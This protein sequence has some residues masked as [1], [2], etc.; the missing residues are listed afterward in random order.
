MVPQGFILDAF[1]R[2]PVML[3]MAEVGPAC[4]PQPSGHPEQLQLCRSYGRVPCFWCRLHFAFL[5]RNSAS[6]SLAHS[7]CLVR[8]AEPRLFCCPA[9]ETQVFHGTDTQII[10]LQAHVL[11]AHSWLLQVLDCSLCNSL[12]NS[13]LQLQISLCRAGGLCAETSCESPMSSVCLLFVCFTNSWF[14]SLTTGVSSLPKNPLVCLNGP[15]CCLQVTTG[16]WGW[17][18]LPWALKTH[19]NKSFT[20]LQGLG[21]CLISF[22]LPGFP[23][24][25]FPNFFH[26]FFPLQRKPFSLDLSESQCCWFSCHFCWDSELN[27]WKCLGTGFISLVFNACGWVKKA[28]RP[29]K[30]C[31]IHVLLGWETCNVYLK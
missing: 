16:T 31:E 13:S 24:D 23:A 27:H 7:R 5:G 21:W 17:V 4:C 1:P 26:F 30:I 2:D 18:M 8:M 20:S 15:C 12:F 22:F 6:F 19:S 9:S 25:F 3:L 29:A 10:Y 11:L 14:S 28:V